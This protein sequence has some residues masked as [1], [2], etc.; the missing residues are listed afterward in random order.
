MFSEKIRML[1]QERKMSQPAVAAEMGLS[2][3]G[4]QNLELGAVPRYSSLLCV[5]NF[6]NVSADWLMGRT[7]KRETQSK[8]PILNQQETVAMTFAEKIRMLRIER[9]LSQ[10]AAGE[11]MGL[12]MRGLQDIELGKLPRYESLLRIADFYDVS[13]DWLVGRTERRDAHRL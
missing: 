1:R 11:G 5:A 8:S 12:S 3:R 2:M 4:Y 6:Y 10:T 9:N 7:E 13:I